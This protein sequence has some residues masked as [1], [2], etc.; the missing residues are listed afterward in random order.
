M[1]NSLRKA[2]SSSSLGLLQDH[3]HPTSRLIFSGL[4]FS[5]VLAFL[6]FFHM[7]VATLSTRS[8]EDY[9]HAP[10]HTFDNE[11]PSYSVGGGNADPIPF[12]PRTE[13]VPVLKVAVSNSQRTYG[14]GD[15]IYGNM[16]LAPKQQVSVANI[17]MML[18]VEEIAIKPGWSKDIVTR[19]RITLAT[20][21]VP[22]SAFSSDSVGRPGYIYSFPFVIQI[23]EAKSLSS[24]LLQFDDT[25][26]SPMEYMRLAP[27]L[28]SPPEFL[29]P[30]Y[31]LPGNIVRISYR[32]RATVRTRILKSRE[33]YKL[34][35]GYS[36]IHVTPSYSLSPTAAKRTTKELHTI[37]HSIKKGKLKKV[38]F[39]VMEMQMKKL[40]N[41]SLKSHL[42]APLTLSFRPDNPSNGPP[43][44]Q[45]IK[46]TLVS[47]TLYSSE[48][49]FATSPPGETHDG[50]N[51]IFQQ[52]PLAKLSPESSSISW[53]FNALSR[54]YVAD[55]LI[56]LTLAD[57]RRIIPTFESCFISRDYSLEIRLQLDS[58]SKSSPMISVPVNLVASTNPTSTFPFGNTSQ[59][60]SA[61][62]L[63]SP[64][65]YLPPATFERSP[66]HSPFARLVEPGVSD[67]IYRESAIF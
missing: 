7:S 9:I 22:D 39:G 47:R 41:F 61:S 42:T 60:Q 57:D 49:T 63:T 54:K 27:T 18:E 15:V 23:P 14:L 62:T 3:C 26:A 50:I 53:D 33:T 30:E 19:R 28:G 46:I 35:N 8:S 6:I 40:P 1:T 31:D 65:T 10:N 67:P 45:Q 32:L 2:I 59:S 21:T 48:G 5:K 11:P 34:D 4:S 44:I 66:V 56:P 12:N 24:S 52:V 51:A 25:N 16:L 29:F 64:D 13:R 55:L 38:N 20:H 43:T 36:Y 17:A 58:N 37:Q